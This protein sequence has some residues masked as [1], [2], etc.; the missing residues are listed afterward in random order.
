MQLIYGTGNEAKLA[1]MRRV[2]E[3]LPFEVVGLYEAAKQQGLEVPC[4]EETGQT[5]LENAVQKAEAYYQLFGCPVF[6][7]DSGLYLWNHDTG[8]MLPPEE[9]PGI[10]V[11]GRGERRLSDEELL[12]HYTGLVQKYGLIRA[13]YKN[14]ICLIWSEKQRWESMDETL[15]GAPFLF[16]HKPHP[17][18][19][20]GFPLDSISLEMTTRKYYYDLG[21]NSQDEVAADK[22]WRGFFE[23]LLKNVE[24]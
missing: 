7:C 13:R 5:P 17:R 2:L 10:H 6:S 16:T 11:R 15:W 19:V 3:G 14:A 12:E 20:E 9:Q 8:E 21:D 24:I 23:R 22:G 1:S 4:V 18:R